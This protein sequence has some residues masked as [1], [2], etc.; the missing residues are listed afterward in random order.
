[1]T[2]GQKHD[3]EKASEAQAQKNGDR[4]NF[5]DDLGNRFETADA[6]E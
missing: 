6:A 4:E 3:H 2:V 1:M 5:Q